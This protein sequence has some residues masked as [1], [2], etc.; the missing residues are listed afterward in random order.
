VTLKLAE[1]SVVKSRPSVPYAANFIL[2]IESLCVSLFLMHSHSFEQICTEFDV[3]SLYPP[4]RYGGSVL[5]LSLRACAANTVHTPL[6][7]TG[8]LRW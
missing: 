7:M 5:R 6:E 2:C 8:E 4:D 1:M 3:A